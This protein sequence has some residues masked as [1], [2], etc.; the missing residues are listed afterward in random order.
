[1]PTADVPILMYHSINDHPQATPLGFLS[2]SS[3]EF[4]AHLQYLRK[5]G[6]LCVTVTDLWRLA[7]AGS[8]PMQKV[9]SLTFDDGYLDNLLIAADI[10]DEFGAK[11]TLFAC[12]DFIDTGP[13]R[14]LLNVPDAWG[15]LNEAELRHLQ[16]RGT[17]D[18]QCHT[19]THDREFV[20]DR[21][22]DFLRPQVLERF[23]WMAWRLDRPGKPAWFERLRE[24]WRTLPL[25]YPIF[26][27]DRALRTRRFIPSESFIA[28]AQAAFAERGP[29]C[30]DAINADKNKGAFESPQQHRERLTSELADSKARLEKMLHKSIDLLC[31]PGGGY[32]DEALTIAQQ[33]GYKAY[34]LRYD[35]R[36][37][38]NLR[39]LEEGVGASAIVPLSRL[40]LGKHYPPMVSPSRGAYLDCKLR[41]EA[42][43]RRPVPRLVLWAASLSRRRRSRP[44]DAARGSE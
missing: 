18:I 19:M 21:V 4:R 44:A 5:N 33:C 14:T 40:S 34:L 29:D 20:S 10:L 12:T 8:L 26:E 32:D 30:L 1:M 11:A 2:F 41:V 35:Q 22:I 42:F 31:F 13:R 15:Y 7:E 23:Y 3:A 43:L 6:Y 37:R 17:F 36:D 25:G 16:E 39:R 38:G 28:R 9:V 27:H 24:Y